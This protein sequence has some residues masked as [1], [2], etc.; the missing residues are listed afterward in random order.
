[1]S[2][3]KDAIGIQ[4]DIIG[5]ITGQTAADAATA[6]GQTILQG[7]REGIAAT[8]AATE[9]GLGFLQPFAGIGQQGI[10]QAGFLTDPQAQFDFLQSNPLFQAALNQANTS[11]QNMAAARGRLS[12]GDTLQQLSQNVLLSA[13]PL[14]SEQKR[15]IA[16]LLNVGTGIAQT[17][18]NTAI[19][20]GS[21]VANLTTGG[22]QAVAAGQVGAA[23]AQQQGIQNLL[24]GAATVAPF[25]SDKRLKS[26]IKKVGEKNGH[27][28]YTWTWNKI[29][30]ALGLSGDSKG[31]LA[32]EVLLT[33]PEAVVAK[34]GFLRVNYAMIGVKHGN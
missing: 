5:G 26:N 7:T 3:V 10:E 4:K 15:S 28:I 17:Q 22:A 24:S 27:N 2:I 8:E 11:T 23:N 1:V 18:A 31:V 33:H 30:E 20:Q 19:N 6:S 32:N 29:A 9:Q 34:D 25:L 16:D 14:I 21:N 13:S 12:A